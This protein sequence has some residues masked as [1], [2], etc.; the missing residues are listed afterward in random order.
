MGRALARR[1]RP[2]RAA[3]PLVRAF[4]DHAGR[5]GI[6]A[7]ALVAAGAVLESAGLLLLVPILGIVTAPAAAAPGVVESGLRAVGLLTPT[8]RLLALLAV[9]AGVMVLR[10]LVLHAR[11]MALARLQTGFIEAQRNRVMRAL[12]AAP[13]ERVAS[14]RHARVMN[15]MSAEMQ[16]V[17]V[18]VHFLLQA[19]VAAAMLAIQIA[20]AFW[21]APALA[22]AAGA[23]LLLGGGV[24]LLAQGRPHGFGTETVQFSQSL[25]SSAGAFLGGL[26]TAAAQDAQGFF[27]DEFA[28][29]QARL[30]ESQLRFAAHRARSRLV[31]GTAVAV[32]GGAVVLVGFAVFRV[33][34][35]VLI[36]LVLVFARMS[37]PALLIQ[38]AV[39]SFFHGVASFEA[40]DALVADLAA[41]APPAAGTATAA[42][43]PDDGAGVPAGAIAFRGVRFL[44]PGGG[45]LQSVDL[46]IAP[47]TFLGIAGPSGAGKTTLVDLLV[48]LL[49]P[50]SGEIRLGGAPLAGARAAAWRRGVAYVAQDGFLF[51]DTV[52][53][54]LLWDA[55]GIDDATIA[56]ALATVGAD[57]LVARLPQGLETV[58]GERGALLSGGE[59]QRL[60]LARALLR[61]PALLVLDEATNA[62]DRASEAAV[63]GA[64]AVCSPRPTIVM[65]THR[66][67]SL[68]FC[69]RVV[70][71]AGG[72]VR[73]GSAG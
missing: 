66:A 69:D 9:F 23:A 35:A 55:D 34:A 2:W 57:G 5:T 50:Q 62:L 68:A 22:A 27:A 61:R 36:T 43:P 15:I 7:A 14:L 26:K 60:S 65:I 16:R 39:Q 40:L 73:E 33:E 13:W 29:L 8:A 70:H 18:S 37:G 32:L 4:R 17:G 3:G 56:A 44:H 20:T 41:P 71:I 54:N 1:L 6:A 21:L 45:G 25:M 19:G 49:A 11:E 67:E 47:G 63:L 53:R 51:H 12:A 52:R 59:R 58:I 31:L 42:A 30:R 28:G 48:G 24:L 64:L 46:A 10:A 38:Q 72:V